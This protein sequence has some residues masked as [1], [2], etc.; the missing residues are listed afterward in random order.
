MKLEPR[1][2]HVLGRFVIKRKLSTIVIPNEA[3]GVSKFIVVDAVGPDAEAAGIKVGDMITPKT[4]LSPKGG[5]AYLFS[6]IITDEGQ[7]PL[8]EEPNIAAI[9][10]D[11]NLNEFLVQTESGAKYV[12]FD[13]D[14]AAK[15]IGPLRKDR[16]KANHEHEA[17]A[18]APV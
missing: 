5:L 3:A 17:F 12:P 13:S 6:A 15:P 9:V 10:S 7:R 8:I 14:E 16:P 4:V 18:G 11:L 2:N 1:R